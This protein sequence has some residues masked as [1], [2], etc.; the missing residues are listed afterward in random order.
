MLILLVYFLLLK[1]DHLL[2]FIKMNNHIF[3]LSGILSVMLLPPTITGEFLT[4]TAP[5]AFG[6]Q[7]MF[8][9]FDKDS[10]GSVSDTKNNNNN[11][12]ITDYNIVPVSTTIGTNGTSSA[13]SGNMTETIPTI[14]VLDV[15][16]S[17]YIV[18]RDL[19]EDES[20]R[21]ISRAIRD[22]INDVFHTV[23]A[24]NAT[25]ISTA[26]IT[27]SFLDESTTVNNYTRLL[28]IIPDQ[29]EAALAG[30]RAMSQ[31]ANPLLE[32]HTDLQA[33]CIANVTSLADCDMNIRIR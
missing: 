18:P 2:S 25:I 20:E 33:V 8:D 26:T 22:R 32:L 19:D 7:V 28:E 29:V 12:N 30:I 3:I 31:P 21:R 16:N 24:S 23:V 15:I 10:G 9:S 6:Q 4:L 1:I 17:T 11:N 5:N 14:T 13:P 27:N